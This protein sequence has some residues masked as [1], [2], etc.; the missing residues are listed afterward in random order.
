M[1]LLN[2]SCSRSKSLKVDELGFDPKSNSR[3]YALIIKETGFKN[4]VG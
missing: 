4:S 2:I 3:D 1:G